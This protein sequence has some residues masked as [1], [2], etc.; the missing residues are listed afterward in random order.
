MNLRFDAWILGVLLLGLGAAQALP[1]AAALLFGESPGPFLLAAGV[2]VVLGGGVAWLART[3]DR[4]LRPRDAYVIVAG[5]WLL[6]SL[7]GA[8]PYWA[9]GVLAPVDAFFEAV[10]GF[11]TT[12]STVMARI[13]DTDRSLLLWRAFTQ[14]VGGMGIVLFAVA[15]LP[16]LGIGGMQLFRV[17]VPGPVKDKLRPRIAET[18]RR[19]WAIYLGLT[20]AAGVALFLAGLSAFEAICHAFTAVATGG[21]STRDA[22]IG[23]FGS[24]LVEWILIAFMA[25]A[26]INFLLHYRTLT[27]GPRSVVGDRELRYYGAVLLGAVLV[28]VWMVPGS[29]ADSAVEALRHAAF[30]VVSI[31][32]TTG[33]GTAD[34]EQWPAL[35]QLVL[36]QLMILGGMAGSTSGGV[37]SLR[38]LIGFRALGATIEKLVHPRSVRTVKYGGRAVPDDVMATLWA[39]FTAYFVLAALA[40]AVVAQAGYDVVTAVSAALTAMS[41]VGP[42][43][44]AIGPTDTFAHFPG[45]V[46]LALSAC[47]LAGRLE[48]FTFLVVVMPGFWRR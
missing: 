41:N 32:T 4:V 47:M 20:V 24:P 23:A 30:S 7:L 1:A 6:A 29:Q 5:G 19:L 21:F 43:L 31:T 36:L 44:G 2:A 3:R 27:A 16:L 25:L 17:E 13:E 9:S 28:V 8:I 42:G 11:T 40:T 48:I 18:A 26:G 14:W 46:K 22:S 12:G 34:F 33:Y 45:H 35:A 15:V 38:V 10:A 37:K 39:F